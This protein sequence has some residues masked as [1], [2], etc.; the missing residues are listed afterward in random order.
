MRTKESAHE[1]WA[2]IDRSGKVL[3]SRG[4]SSTPSRLMVYDSE[5]RAHS[6]LNNS[7]S[8]QIP[9]IEFAAVKMLYKAL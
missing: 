8:R 2:V 5:K 4:G 6:A 9:G 1:I 3:Y 7:W